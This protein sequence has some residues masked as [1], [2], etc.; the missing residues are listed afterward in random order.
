MLAKK[1]NLK[2]MFFICT[3]VKGNAKDQESIGLCTTPDP[4]Q[5]MVK[6]TKTQKHTLEI[7]E[8]SPFPAG[9]HKAARNRQEIITKTNM[10]H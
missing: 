7:Q 1:L 2:N 10:I 9:D 4:R 6:P 3:K 5:H 8:V